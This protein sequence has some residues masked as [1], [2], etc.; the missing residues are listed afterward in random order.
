MRLLIFGFVDQMA[1]SVAS[2]NYLVIEE[3]LRRGHKI[4]FVHVPGW[5]DPPPALLEYPHFGAVAVEGASV[6][7]KFRRGTNVLLDQGLGVI[8]LAATMQRVRSAMLHRIGFT[9]VSVFLGLAPPFK[10]PM[11]VVAWL[12]GPFRTE[13][14]A[15][16]LHRRA[17]EAS[18]GRARYVAARLFYLVRN[19]SL[20]LVRKRATKWICGSPWAATQLAREGFNLRS[21]TY[22]PYPI[23]LDLFAPPRLVQSVDPPVVLS[24]GRLDPRKRVD[25]LLESMGAVR[26]AYPG[27]RCL[28][29]GRQGAF[30][31]PVELACEDLHVSHIESVP[32]FQVP[33][34]MHSS[35][36]LVQT[37]ESENFGSSVAEALACGTPVVL[38]PTNGTGDYLK[39]CS[40]VFPF[41]DYNAVSV[42]KAIINAIHERTAR[43]RETVEAARE[44]ATRLFS[45]SSIVDQ[46]LAV[47]TDAYDE[48][49]SE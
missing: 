5:V 1:G 3:L 42:S 40:S 23:D 18:S 14:Q 27:V 41:E 43:P 35:S 30:G 11:A 13:T 36:V 37:S 33:S 39:N 17:I 45:T 29:V 19:A 15:L 21:I 34:L 49:Q 31:R 2:A 6:T 28:I 12:Q 22:L 8:D 38:G 48:A 32:R 16:K 26:E 24:L 10:L 9:D 46:F 7:T 4:D 25:L 47:V 20:P 44:W